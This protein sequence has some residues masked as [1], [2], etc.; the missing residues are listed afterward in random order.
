VRIVYGAPSRLLAGRMRDLARKHVIDL[1][2]SR[3][4]YNDDGW[5]EVRTHAKYVL[6]KG[7]I[8]RDRRAHAVWTGSQNWVTGSLS[9]SDETSL[10][11]ALRSAY[12]S[13]L[14]NWDAI[15]DHS[16]RL[17]YDVYGR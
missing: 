15:R 1:W 5:S 7:T 6:V 2:D 16:R 14:K 4:D 11:I 17:P 9:V 13:Y 3:W 10:N 12:R 8:G